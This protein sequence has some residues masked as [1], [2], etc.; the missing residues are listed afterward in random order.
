MSE[1]LTEPGTCLA[2][3]GTN[4]RFANCETGDITGFNSV[5]TPDKPPEFFEW[6]ARR[7]L[8]ASDEGKHWLV[9]GFPGPV[10]PNGLFV[11]PLNN[12]A[13]MRTEK[14]DLHKEL[15]SA[16]KEVTKVIE[17]GFT[18]LAVND[19]TLASQAAASRIGNNNYTKT[20]T[21]IIGTGVGAG[22]VEKD[23]DYT[24]VHR[25]DKNNPNEI[26]HIMLSSNP[27]DTFENRYSGPALLRRYGVGAEELPANHPAWA[28]EGV[29]IGMMA[30]TL[31]L[32]SN[33]GLVVPTGGLGAG[34]S[35]KYGRHL[36]KFMDTYKDFANGPQKEYTPDIALVPASQSKEFEMYGAEGVIRDHLTS[37]TEAPADP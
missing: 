16:D 32:M 23:P 5:A 2:F 6:M 26:G 20:G 28:E 33:V 10:S 4:A 1:V 9:A 31:S 34:A 29:A 13:G 30:T 24:N 3:G 14:Y 21:L 17:Q 37:E 19:G 15:K 11:G 22:I 25:A 18:L 35:H 12:V 27:F 8:D 7:V 36:K